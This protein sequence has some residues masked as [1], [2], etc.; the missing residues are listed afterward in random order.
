MASQLI[1][2]MTE[3][4]E[5][6]KYRDTFRDDIITLVNRKIKAGN[7]QVVTEAP[8]GEA[9]HKSSNVIDLTELLKRSLRSG[10]RTPAT[11]RDKTS[12]ARKS[13]PANTGQ[14]KKEKAA[15]KRKPA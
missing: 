11:G 3:K 6:A 8:S 13:A 1:K 5:I 9:E 12:T 14:A 7:T 2:D 10:N 15:L 4:F